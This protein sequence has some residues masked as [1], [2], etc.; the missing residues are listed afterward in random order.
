MDDSRDGRPLFA[1]LARGDIEALGPLYDAHAGPVYRVLLARGVDETAAEDVLQEV[2]LSL[3]D[4]GRVLARVEN[5][6]AYLLG[7]AR[8]MAGRQ[9]RR[10][11]RRG[12]PSN[13][14]PSA[15]SLTGDMLAEGVAV[16][17]ALQE[18]PPEQAE[19]VVLKVWEE[20]TFAEIA[21]ALEISPNT[22]ASRY[23][24]ALDKLRTVWGENSDER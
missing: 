24:Y 3:L 2:F 17:E 22:A 7:I 20:L 13:P 15:E 19:V 23:R 1:A 18:L 5:V 10:Q 4:R 6:R 21:S 11:H 8:N 16:R 14:G 12:Q 9:L